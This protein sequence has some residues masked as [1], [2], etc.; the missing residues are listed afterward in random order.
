MELIV[1]SHPECFPEEDQLLRLLF[2]NGLMRFHLRK[3]RSCEQDVENLLQKLPPEY[4]P[5]IA[6]HDHLNLAVRFAL[7][8]VHLN[9]RNPVPPVDYTGRRSASC[10]SLQEV[11]SRK[12]EMD[13]VFLSPVFDSISKEGYA[14][15]FTTETL[16]EASEKGIIDR[17]V[18]ALGGVTPARI[19]YLHQLGFGGVAVLGTLWN[20]P[21]AQAV[22]RAFAETKEAITSTRL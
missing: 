12:K 1:I 22:L 10:H 6:L 7:G 15:A 5:R 16:K 2:E 11:S 18:I 8:G 13:Y 4:Y 20:T 21:S 3:P 17:K 19:P 14:S 9:G